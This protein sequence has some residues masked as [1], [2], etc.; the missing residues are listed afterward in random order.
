MPSQ[1]IDRSKL[2]DLLS[3][4]EIAARYR[5]AWGAD[6]GLDEA[7][8]HARLEGELTDRLRSTSADDRWEAFSQAYTRLY[9]ELPWMN[10]VEA[11]SRPRDL[12]AWAS[13][14]GRGKTVL[15][16]GSGAAHLICHLAAKGNACHAT[17]ITPSRTRA[18]DRIEWR[19]SDG[20]N[21]TRFFQPGSYDVVISDQVFEHLHPEDH[22][23]HLTEV[24]KILRDGGR[25]IL[26]APHRATGPHDL[27]SVF[28][29]DSAVF[30]HLQEPDHSGLSDM[31]ARAGFR[32]RSAVLSLQRLGF[33]IASPAF[34]RY[35]CIV[36]GVERR[37]GLSG[38][39]RR[40]F[41]RILKYFLVNPHVWVIATK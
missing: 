21:L 27:S 30:L 12:D 5:A 31:L 20:V 14:V 9:E 10:A 3:P 25:Y 1:V 17:E 29:F 41:R 40:R 18:W 34:L 6:V 35:Q 11:A 26:R 23:R 13:L 38:E 33:A 15:E 39:R 19:R 8:A 28:G 2:L 16:I 7:V 24:R 4:D 36:E 22:L 37:L 32:Q